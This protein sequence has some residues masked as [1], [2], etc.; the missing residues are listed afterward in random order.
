VYP[1]G[2]PGAAGVG[3]LRDLLTSRTVLVGVGN[4]LR[5]DDAFGPL[6]VHEI[7]ARRYQL[8]IIDAGTAPENQISQI[9]RFNPVCVVLVDTVHFGAAPGVFRI[10]LSSDHGIASLTTHGMHI[11]I[12][13]EE[14]EA[15]TGATTVLLGVQPQNLSIGGR[16]SPPVEASLNAALD[17]IA[18]W[19]AAQPPTAQD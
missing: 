4:T 6:L 9:A 2:E 17:E 13:M 5:G 16:L 11:S 10:C 3:C 8:K 12:A 15:R 7:S 14:I 19:S 18:A 1:W